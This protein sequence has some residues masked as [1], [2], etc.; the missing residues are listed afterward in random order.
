MQQTYPVLFKICPLT[1]RTQAILLV[2][3]AIYLLKV[4]SDG[5]EYASPWQV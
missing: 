4:S 1:M 5:G 2:R 3:D